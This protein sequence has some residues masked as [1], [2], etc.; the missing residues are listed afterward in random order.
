MKNKEIN[1]KHQIQETQKGKWKLEKESLWPT[2]KWNK[3]KRK[4]EKT[5]EHMNYKH[6]KQTTWEVKNALN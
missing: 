3:P 6:A 2:L 5:K 4:K 1:K